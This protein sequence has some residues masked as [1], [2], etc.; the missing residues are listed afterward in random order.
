[1]KEGKSLQDLARRLEQIR[2]EKQD[3]VIDTRGIKLEPVPSGKHLV[4]NVMD[5]QEFVVRPHA[6]RQIESRVG[7][8][9]KFADR[10]LK[11]HP[12]MLCD[13]I[14]KLFQRE[15]ERRLVRTLRT[16]MRAF[17]SDGYRIM[18]NFDLA[19]AIL[20]TLIE[21]GAEVTSCDVTETKMYIKAIRPDLEREFGPPEGYQ[22]GV[23]HNFF[24]EKVQAGLTISNSEVGAGGLNV[25][26]SV[27]TERCTNYCSFSNS[28]YR[29]VHLGKKATGDSDSMIWDVMSDETRKL[30][31]KALWSQVRD[32][33]VAAMDGTL[34]D[35]IVAELQKARGDVIE[36]DPVKMIERVTDRFGFTETEQG[37]VL[38][39]LI[40]GGDLTRYGLHAAVTRTAEDVETYDRATEFENIGGKIIELPSRDWEVLAAAA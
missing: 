15:P 21:H 29:K 10:L 35:K 17:L 39:H 5:Q 22:M 16:D 36:G 37:S 25:Q 24:V 18:D 20:P 4:A 9:A 3:Y 27:F 34:F 26:P 38:N 31:D 19:E 1:M 7:V 13:T 32:V 6:L 14:T 28:N 11:D 12:D 30:S 2:D 8:P 23:G 40:A 33:A